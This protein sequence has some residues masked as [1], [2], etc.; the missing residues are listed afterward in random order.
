M[1]KIQKIAVKTIGFIIQ[2]KLSIDFVQII[3]SEANSFWNNP[4]AS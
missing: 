3:S 1:V 2:L 4:T